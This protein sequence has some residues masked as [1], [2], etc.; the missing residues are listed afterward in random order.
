MKKIGKDKKKKAQEQRPSARKCP[1]NFKLPR[2]RQETGML[3]K[4]G[5]V[6]KGIAMDVGRHGGPEKL[7]KKRGG[8]IGVLTERKIR[9]SKRGHC[10]R[11]GKQKREGGVG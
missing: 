5:K 6:R 4:W 7:L 10:K 11:K 8:Q 1:A 9:M 3:T 2:E